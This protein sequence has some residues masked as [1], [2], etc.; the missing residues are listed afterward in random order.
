[1]FQGEYRLAAENFWIPIH[2]IAISLLSIALV[3]NW[4]TVRRN[5]ILVTLAGYA[6]VL[7]ITFIYFVP[8]LMSL[9]QSA[10]SPTTNE[11][12]TRRAG[13]WEALSLVRLVFLIGL[14]VVLLLGLS[15]PVGDPRGKHV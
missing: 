6:L 4:R 12:L 8:E 10:Y 15:R 2:P 5:Y 1:M 11:E 7:V 14:S 13:L 3:F 9:T